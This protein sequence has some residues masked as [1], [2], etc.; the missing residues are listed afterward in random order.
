MLLLL[1]E[2]HHE[3]IRNHEQSSIRIWFGWTIPPSSWKLTVPSPTASCISWS[4]S[5]SPLSI[6]S[7]VYK[8]KP[9]FVSMIVDVPPLVSSLCFFKWSMKAL[10]VWS[11]AAGDFCAKYRSCIN[12]HHTLLVTPPVQLATFNYWSKEGRKYLFYFL[13]CYIFN[14]FAR[15]KI[16]F[17]LLNNV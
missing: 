13:Y 17:L 15:T 5:S 9:S 1:V 11:R 4:G 14:I 3:K 8:F 16:G 10:S 7:D 6:I 12:K 2:S